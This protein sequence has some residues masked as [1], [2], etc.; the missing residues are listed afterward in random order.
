MDMAYVPCIHANGLIPTS[1]L[2]VNTLTNF[3]ALTGDLDVQYGLDDVPMSL[4][5]DTMAGFMSLP[6]I[7]GSNVYGNSYPNMIF[8]STVDSTSMPLVVSGMLQFIAISAESISG[9]VI[10]NGG[11]V[12]PCSGA[13]TFTMTYIGPPC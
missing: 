7:G 2:Y 11:G 13:A 8:G 12:N 4:T 9:Y 5:Y 10:V 1:L 3:P 6:N